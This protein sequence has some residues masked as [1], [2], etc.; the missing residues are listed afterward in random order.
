MTHGTD[1]GPSANAS[2]GASAAHENGWAGTG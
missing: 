1:A 2:L